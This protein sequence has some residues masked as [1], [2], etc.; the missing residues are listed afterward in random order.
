MKLNETNI[1]DCEMIA[2][3]LAGEMTGEEFSRFENDALSSP[4][5]I[6][7]INAMKNNWTQIGNYQGNKPVDADKAWNKL[8]GKLN[9]ENL[10]PEKNSPEIYYMPVWLKYAASVLLLAT[11]GIV[12]LY[13]HSN[14]K[15][16]LVNLKTGDE[17]NTLVQTL[18]DGS[19]IYLAKN[20]SLSYPDRFAKNERMVSLSGEAFF[21]ITPKPDQPF[22]IETGTAI[23]EVLGTAFNVK[24]ENPNQFELIVERGKVRVTLK[25]NPTQNTIVIPGEKIVVANNQL[26]KSKVDGYRYPWRTQRIKFKDETLE[27]IIRVINKNYHSNIIIPSKELQNRRLT[28]TFYNNSLAKVTELICISLNLQSEV[29]KDS[30]III[31]PNSD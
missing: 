25:K 26:E 20:T 24:S 1:N 15:T 16:E 6:N 29:D 13:I 18:A 31:K 7:L 4:E 11:I 8:Y 9:S 22:K 21:D 5:N 12:T 27:N 30:T 17:A 23:I 2:R 28:V 14:P 10:I 19:V 3:Y